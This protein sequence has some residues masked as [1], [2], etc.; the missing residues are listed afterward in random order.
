MCTH[1]GRC[2]KSP[3]EDIGYPAA[4]EK[5]KIGAGNQT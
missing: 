3:E 1:E 4:G 5:P 2:L